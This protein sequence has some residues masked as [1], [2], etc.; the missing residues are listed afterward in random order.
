MYCVKCRGPRTPAENMVD[1]QPINE[2]IGNLIA[3]CSCCHSIMNRRVSLANLEHALSKKIITHL[4]AQEYINDLI[5]EH[6]EALLVE[7]IAVLI[8]NYPIEILEVKDNRVKRAWVF[9]Y[10]GSV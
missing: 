6:L 2:K 9:P 7:H 1:Y 10:Y 8:N 3:I 5:I 4:P